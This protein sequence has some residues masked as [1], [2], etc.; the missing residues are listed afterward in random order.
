MSCAINKALVPYPAQG[1][2]SDCF[3]ISITREHMSTLFGLNWLNDEVSVC[4]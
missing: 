3:N 1:V 2:L 4:N